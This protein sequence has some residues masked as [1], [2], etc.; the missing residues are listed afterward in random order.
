[1]GSDKLALA[2]GGETLLA[3]TLRLVREAADEV[4]LVAREGQ[5]L[6]GG[7]EALRDPAEGLGPLAGIAIGLEAVRGERAFVAAADMPLLRPALVS[8]LLAL[9]RGYDACVAVV[10]GIPVPTCAVYAKSLAARAHGLV[11]ARELRASALADAVRTRH[12]APDELRDV[13]PELESFLDCDTPA[14]Y[15]AALRRAGLATGL[16]AARRS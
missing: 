12:V 5:E 10:D 11:A 14:D 2:F 15:E 16:T 13:D 6:P 1:M 9:S 7:L 8:R 4:V 3:R